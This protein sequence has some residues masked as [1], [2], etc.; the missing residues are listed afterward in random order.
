MESK[1]VKI[2]SVKIGT[3][4]IKNFQ[5]I[6]LDLSHVNSTYQMLN[7]KPLDGVLGND[8]LKK[9]NAVISFPSKTVII[10]IKKVSPNSTPKERTS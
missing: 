6:L 4:E 2:N 10:S 5:M 7:H 8:V 1:M 3:Y 9:A